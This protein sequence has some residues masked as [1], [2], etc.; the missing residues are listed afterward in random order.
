MR[1]ND[2][3]AI[4]NQHH[5]L[6]CQVLLEKQSPEEKLNTSQRKYDNI[7]GSL[8]KQSKVVL[9]ISRM[10]DIREELLELQYLPVD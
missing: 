10:L 3:E 9:V 4:D 7:F 6:Q 5:I 8:E 1:C 2:L